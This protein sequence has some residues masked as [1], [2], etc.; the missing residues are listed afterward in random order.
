MNFTGCR[1]AAGVLAAAIIPGPSALTAGEDSSAVQ[2]PAA[3]ACADSAS[4]VAKR[5]ARRQ[6]GDDNSLKRLRQVAR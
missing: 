2:N 3:V 5:H 6:D 4:N 1:I